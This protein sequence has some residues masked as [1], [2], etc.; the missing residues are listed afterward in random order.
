LKQQPKEREERKMTAL[1]YLVGNEKFVSYEK[2]LMRGAEVGK[3]PVAEYQ[4][5]FETSK[6]NAESREKRAAAIRAGKRTTQ[7][8][9]K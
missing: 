1:T 4:P 5:I 7:R 6:V 3:K 8:F 2:A 9:Q